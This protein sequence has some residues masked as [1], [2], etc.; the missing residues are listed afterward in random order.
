M[1]IN[2]FVLALIAALGG[3]SQSAKSGPS[4]DEIRSAIAM[5]QSAEP[6]PYKL[7]SIF[8]TNTHP[9]AL[10]Y[11]P[12]VRIGRASSEAR[13]LG[14]PFDVEDIGPDDSSPLLHV[15]MSADTV[16]P[17]GIVTENDAVH[18][19]VIKKP[20]QRFL[21]SP[22]SSKA[23]WVRHESKRPIAALPGSSHMGVV[24]GAFSREQLCADCYVVAYRMHRTP[25]GHKEIVA[26]WAVIKKADVDS[27]R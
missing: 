22:E 26:S 6:E 12:Y 24:V 8:P 4:S 2:V 5:G 9:A 1:L 23:A 25:E 7:R 20:L 14:K 13:R 15:V 16:P 3:L 21:G 10:V 11:T 18:M 17:A 19:E 27:W